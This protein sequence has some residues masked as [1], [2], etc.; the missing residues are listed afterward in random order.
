MS[1][2]QLG[3]WAERKREEEYEADMQAERYAAEA[4][5][6]YI[7]AFNLQASVPGQLHEP[8]KFASYVNGEP[9]QFHKLL[10]AA[11]EELL[12]NEDGNRTMGI[13]SEALCHY[14][15]ASGDKDARKLMQTLADVSAGMECE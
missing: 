15:A 1:Y 4:R 11:L 14:T 2:Y 9:R 5:E 10:T 7:R 3:E 13:L 12:S 8:A 6:D